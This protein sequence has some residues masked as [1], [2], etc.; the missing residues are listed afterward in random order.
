MIHEQYYTRQYYESVP[1]KILYTS[2]IISKFESSLD[3]ASSL[4]GY[5][6]LNSNATIALT[7]IKAMR[8]TNETSIS[9]ICVVEKH[10]IS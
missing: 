6:S 4:T 5:V 9:I 1:I 7:D 2:M 10:P 8:H 3:R